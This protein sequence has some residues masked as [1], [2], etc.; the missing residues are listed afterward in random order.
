MRLRSMAPADVD[1]VCEMFLS[2]DWGDRRQHFDF[3]LRHEWQTPFVAEAASEIV[4]V[5][6]A[7]QYGA[8][9]W[10]GQ[11]MVAQAARRQGVGEAI[12]RTLMDHLRERGCQSLALT[13]TPMGYPLYQKL[14]FAENGSYHMFHGPLATD[15]E[16]ERPTVAA[17]VR[18]LTPSDLDAICALDRTVTGEDRARLL[19]ALVAANSEGWIVASENTSTGFALQSPWGN[20]AVIA[21]NA[22][23]ARLLLRIGA[24]PLTPDG[25]ITAF[26]PTENAVGRAALVE[27]GFVEFRQVRRMIWGDPI[28]WQPARLWGVVAMALG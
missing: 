11:I 3:Y 23:D 28:T 25:E 27:A 18:P 6:V 26:V 15:A 14:G 22:D 16:S 12:T 24:P 10:L 13:A 17:R 4:G 21:A 7:T 20:R 2:N 8:T 9:G 1:A 19:H 5:G